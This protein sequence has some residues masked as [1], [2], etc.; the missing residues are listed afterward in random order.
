[1]NLNEN[2]ERKP[3]QTNANCEENEN[4]SQKSIPAFSRADLGLKESRH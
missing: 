1:M 4:S 2:V 3:N